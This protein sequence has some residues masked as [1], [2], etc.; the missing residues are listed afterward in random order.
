MLLC[1]PFTRA[2]LF[3]LS[4]NL[5]LALVSTV[6]AED[7]PTEVAMVTTEEKVEFIMT[8]EAV[9]GCLIRHPF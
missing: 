3:L 8:L 1:A 4:I 6:L 2:N 5:H 7:L 9:K